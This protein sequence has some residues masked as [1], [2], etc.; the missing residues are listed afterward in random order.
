MDGVLL[1]DAPLQDPSEQ[2]TPK[3]KNFCRD[4]GH[5]LPSCS[6][7]GH[8]SPGSGPS[9]ARIKLPSIRQ[10]AHLLRCYP[11]GKILQFHDDGDLIKPK[12]AST[13]SDQDATELPGRNPSKSRKIEREKEQINDELQL[14]CPAARTIVYF[15]LWDASRESIGFR[16]QSRP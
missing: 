14:V 15:P 7:L 9:A 13:K 10:L 3:L 1:F 5:P 16:S 6:V 2:Q 8:Y 4:E 12:A 11:K